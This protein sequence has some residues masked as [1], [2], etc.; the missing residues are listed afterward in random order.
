MKHRVSN[1][2]SS[3]VSGLQG[4]NP[5]AGYPLGASRYPSRPPGD[6]PFSSPHLIPFSPPSLPTTLLTPTQAEDDLNNN[7]TPLG[8]EG[9]ISRVS[10]FTSVGPVCEGDEEVGPP[11]PVKRRL[12]DMDPVDYSLTKDNNNRVVEG[13]P[14]LVRVKVEPTMHLSRNTSEHSGAKDSMWRPW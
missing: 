2:L 6:L 5:A 13:E 10:A 7:N 8:G 4:V 14:R 1:H 9:V 3:C 11:P 12:I